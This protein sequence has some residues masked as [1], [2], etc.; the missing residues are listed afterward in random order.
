[1]AFDR[2]SRFAKRCSWGALGEQGPLGALGPHGP[3]RAHDRPT[4]RAH[5]RPTIGSYSSIGPYSTAI[6]AGGMGEAFL[7]PLAPGRGVA[8]C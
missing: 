2:D 1:M 7:Y 6:G 8:A 5:D 4:I 3:I